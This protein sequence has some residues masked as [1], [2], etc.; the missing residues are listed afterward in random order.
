[1]AVIM[2]GLL[3]FA[4]AGY[5]DFTSQRHQVVV[6]SQYWNQCIPVAEAGVEDTLMNL[7][8]NGISNLAAGGWSTGTNNYYMDRYLDS[9]NIAFY[10]AVVSGNYQCITSTVEGRLYLPTY[11]TTPYL[12]RT[13]QV[14]ASNAPLFDHG[15]VGIQTIDF[16]QPKRLARLRRNQHQ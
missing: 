15:L 5:L 2:T 11:L 9:N 8:C 16:T 6:R 4:I 12:S 7:G 14:V 1:M 13:V 3:T 10:H